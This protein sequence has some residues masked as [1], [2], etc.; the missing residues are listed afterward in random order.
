MKHTLLFITLLTTMLLATLSFSADESS[1]KPSVMVE[2]TATAVAIVVAIDEESRKITL[3]GLEGEIL[4]F[5]AGPEVRNFGQIKRGDQVIMSYYEG[6]AIGFSPKGSGVRE[7][8]DS[9][10]VERAELGEKPGAKITGSIAAIGTVMAIDVE[11]RKVTLKG[12]KKTVV[13]EAS[14][15]IDLS[16]IK[17]GDKVE[18][19]YIQ[20]YA[21]NVI[22]APKVSGTV[23]IESTS[24]AAGV[25]VEWGHGTL[26]MYDG[27]THKFDV[28]GLS[29]LD[30]GI[31]KV[32][33][34]GEVFNLVEAK[35]LSGVFIAGE[36]GAT[37]GG[38]GSVRAMKNGNG[39]VMQLKSTQMGV[40]LT[41]ASEGL[42]ISLDE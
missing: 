19:L 31:S 26:T 13:L 40:K 9:I 22:P 5:T 21:V 15:D 3:K 33:A 24:V 37:F 1:G 16:Q 36:A 42:K 4:A 41:L 25:G 18:A 39:V 17:V 7:R 27:T 38:G 8:V 23:E 35:D 10:D 12:A 2:G 32:S 14:E 20:S 28:I 34:K 30:L 6:F 29:V 11:N